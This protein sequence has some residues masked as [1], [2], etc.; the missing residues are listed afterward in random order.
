MSNLYTAIGLF[1]VTTYLINYTCLQMGL[2]SGQSYLYA[3]VVILSASSV[4]ISTLDNFNLPSAVIQSSYIL[5]SLVGMIRLYY[6]KNHIHFSAE[7]M[8]FI[9][10]KFPGLSKNLARKLLNKG[11]W[12]DGNPDTVLATEGEN[13]EAL[14]YIINGEAAI[15][16]NGSLLSYAGNDSFIGEL[17]ILEEAPA[18]ATVTLS[19]PS[20]YFLIDK[21]ECKKLILRYPEIR[22]ELT[23]SF[24]D[25]MKK[26]LLNRDID[27]VKLNELRQEG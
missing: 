14:A 16:L 5:I 10:S 13:L 2:I 9:S 24:A 18:T 12:I 27:L 1:G 23:H 21:I 11:R 25:E 22:L 26:K 15:Y 8:E 4:L 20:R 3:T 17:T 19:K 6:L 7:E